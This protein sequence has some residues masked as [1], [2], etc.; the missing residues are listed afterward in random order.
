MPDPTPLDLAFDPHLS[1]RQALRWVIGACAGEAQAP[2]QAMVRMAKIDRV[3]TR[4]VAEADRFFL[5]I[6]WDDKD[7]AEH[8][9]EGWMEWLWAI[10]V[11]HGREVDG[12]M[13]ERMA[14]I[15][16]KKERYGSGK[17][18]WR[19]KA[20]EQDQAQPQAP[21]KQIPARTVTRV[22]EIEAMRSVLECLSEHVG[23]V[24]GRCESECVLCE[25]WERLWGSGEVRAVLLITS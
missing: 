10:A 25:R 18:G 2:S 22:D 8:C 12:E 23:E 20:W 17:W 15:V 21:Q 3:V 11:G 7:G 19:A 1:I 24:G 14:K 4:V 16:W 9:E 13:G 5:K 6:G